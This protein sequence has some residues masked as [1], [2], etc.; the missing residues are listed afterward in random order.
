MRV[1][2]CSSVFFLCLHFALSGALARATEKS[3][4]TPILLKSVNSRYQKLSS[5]KATFTQETYSPQLGKGTFSEGRFEFS[6]PNKFRF[7]TIRPEK[8]LFSTDGISAIRLSEKQSPT[9]K[10]ILVERYKDASSLDLDRYFILLRGLGKKSQSKEFDFS[11]N[12]DEKGFFLEIRPRISSD[13]V[14]ITLYFVHS[15][16]A[17]EKIVIEDLVGGKTTLTIMSYDIIK[18]KRT[19]IEVFRPAV[20][21]GAEIK[22]F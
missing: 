9:G 13:L 4:L 3:T 16:I 14:S 8:S 1:K 5:W 15:T 17:P 7:E 19:P 12:R 11:G 10:K 2:G 20:P 18:D 21:S 6:S 22:D